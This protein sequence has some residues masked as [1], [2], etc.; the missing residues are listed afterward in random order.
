MTST[1]SGSNRRRKAVALTGVIAAGLAVASLG[2]YGIARAVPVEFPIVHSEQMPPGATDRVSIADP[3]TAL[4]FARVDTGSGPR[5][6]AVTAYEKG[7][8]SGV[9]LGASFTEPIAAFNRL[10]YAA[11][12]DIAGDPARPRITVASTDTLTSLDTHPHHVGIGTNYKEHQAEA[13]IEEPFVFPKVA[14]LTDSHSPLPA[15]THGLLDYEVE[16]GIVALNDITASTGVPQHLGLVLSNDWTDRELLVSQIEPDDLTGGAGFTNAKSQPGF[17]STGDLFVIP[18][19]WESYYR[20]LRLDLFVNGG[21]R[22]RAEPADLIWDVRT[23]I[24]KTIAAGDRTWDSDGVPTTLTATPGMIPRGTILQTGTPEGVVYRA[25][26]TRQRFLGF[27]EWAG[28]LGTNADTIVDSA[29]KVYVRDATEADVYL[30][31]GDTVVT[32]ADGLGQI[33]TTITAGPRAETE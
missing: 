17:L 19:D 2:S 25:P 16:L 32:R 33:F 27:M 11:I 14:A 30:K 26:D 23:M 22:Q 18:A 1:N 3:A 20:G 21:L 9:D 4:T 15:G 10:G 24:D 8:I 31:P 7:A 5:V 29:L 12:R 28:S 6:L 13:T